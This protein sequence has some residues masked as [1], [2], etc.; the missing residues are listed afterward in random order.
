L[1][2]TDLAA[3]DTIEAGAIL[4]AQGVTLLAEDDDLLAVAKPAGMVAHPAYR[5]LDGTLAD[6]VFAYA[7][8]SGY[9]RPWLLHRLDRE[10]SGVVLFAR[11]ERARRALARQFEQRRV[12]KRY[13]AVVV[14]AL[15]DE[16]EI[17][18]P[19]R[20]DPADR[21]RVIVAEAGKPTHTRYRVLAASDGFALALVEPL[22]GRTHQ[23]RAHLAH[24]GAPLAG[25][26]LYGGASEATLAAGIGRALLHAWELRFR[27]PATSATAAICAPI[28]SDM[29][30]ALSTLR[31]AEEVELAEDALAGMIAR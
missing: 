6:F 24:R 29:R 3:S 11:S 23:I 30:A 13:L 17:S 28:P 4:A 7:A 22:T 2:D 8:R 21:R 5:H 1:A 15:P 12:V 14:G 18:A 31:L 9:S 10:T 16:G 20:R 19:L 25:D 26:A 27:H